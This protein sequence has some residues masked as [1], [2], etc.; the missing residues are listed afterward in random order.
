[1]NLYKHFR[2]WL[3]KHNFHKDAGFLYMTKYYEESICE[4]CGEKIYNYEDSPWF[5]REDIEIYR[6]MEEED[7]S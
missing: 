3:C 7:V 6:K 5:T 1:M 4:F 2:K